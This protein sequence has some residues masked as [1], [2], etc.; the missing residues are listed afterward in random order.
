MEAGFPTS[1]NTAG[2]TPASPARTGSS[3]QSRFDPG[4]RQHRPRPPARPG[5][6]ALLDGHE[7]PA[8]SASAESRDQVEVEA[9]DGFGGYE[10]ATTALLPAATP[11]HRSVPRRGSGR[12]HTRPMPPAHQQHTRGHRGRSGDP[13]T[14]C[15]AHYEPAT[16]CL[17]TAKKPD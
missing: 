1:M 8:L 5:L 6:R 16:H 17:I 4:T 10:I 11:V 2:R 14:E 9:M 13:V 7:D 3:P 12:D 15:D